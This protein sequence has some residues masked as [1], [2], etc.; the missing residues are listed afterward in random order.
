M[1][2]T[3]DRDRPLLRV[4]IPKGS[5]QES[6]VDLFVRA[7][8][9]LQVSERSY[10]PTID[11]PQIQVIMFRAQEMA[12]YVEDGV[13]DVGVT[14]YDWIVENEADVQEVCELTYSKATTRPVRWVLAVPE[15]SKV[16]KPEDLAGGIIATELV[17]TVER[18]FR[19]RNIPV[20]RVEFS[21][22]ATEVKARLVDAI[23]DVTETGSSLAANKLRVVDTVLVS[24]TRLIANKAS[25]QD[26]VKRAKIE[27]LAL[28][29]RGAIAA[30]AKVGLKMNVPRSKLP[31]ILKILPAEK[32]PTVNPLADP[33]WAAVEVVVEERVEREL[34]PKLV[35]AGATGII[36]YALT[37]VVP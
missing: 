19:E 35:R 23:V 9:H 36:S 1:N 15:E 37:K 18:Y 13:L 6:T 28:L 20:K 8:Y 7:G 14:G 27:D 33:D 5:L 2:P 16:Q 30:R 3:G 31:E 32:S 25:W 24:T 10:F 29:L 26:P 21:W 17:R 34:V 12:R 11:D 4:G 22:G